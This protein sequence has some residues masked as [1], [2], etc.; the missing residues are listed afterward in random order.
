MRKKSFREM[1]TIERR[2]M[3]QKRKCL[4][5]L[6]K[7][8]MI[9]AVTLSIILAGV[10][11]FNVFNAKAKSS[12]TDVT[13]Y[14]YYKNIEIQYDDTLWDLAKE[15]YCKERQSMKEYIAEVKRI[16]HLTDDVIVA[17]NHI[18]L[19]YYSSTFVYN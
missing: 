4:Y 12:Q 18:V 11:C 7:R 10:I 5:V 19:P 13:L 14:K 2:R 15:N 17:G 1:N 3:Y 16:N 6:Q 8:I 9:F